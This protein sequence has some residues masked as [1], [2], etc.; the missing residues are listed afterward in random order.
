MTLKKFGIPALPSMFIWLMTPAV[1][2]YLLESL[3]HDVAENMN[4]AIIGLNLIFYYLIYGLLL[5]ISKRSWISLSLGT[6]L[7]MLVGLANYFV[8]EFRSAPIYPWD[9]LSL[10][11]AA[12]VSDNYDYVLEAEAK[13]LV[14]GFLILILIGLWTR[15]N[16]SIKRIRVQAVLFAVLFINNFATFKAPLKMAAGRLL[17]K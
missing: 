1:S 8:L 12:S 9:L 10:K 2:F 16:L 6:F 15:W 7:T 4:G 3:T 11:T 13:P 5:V 17:K 14:L